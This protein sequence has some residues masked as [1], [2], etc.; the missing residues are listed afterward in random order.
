[1]IKIR[2]DTADVNEYMDSKYN[3]YDILSVKA[4]IDNKEATIFIGNYIRITDGHVTVAY[5][6]KEYDTVYGECVNDDIE[7]DILSMIEHQY[8]TD[9]VFSFINGLK[10]H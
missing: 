3:T 10:K 9:N 7:G 6:D 5:K 8:N 1:M 2:F 4:L